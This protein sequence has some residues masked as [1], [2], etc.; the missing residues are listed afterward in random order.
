MSGCKDKA[1][2]IACFCDNGSVVWLSPA[3]RVSVQSAIEIFSPLD[4]SG[5]AEFVK[6]KIATF[7]VGHAAVMLVGFQIRSGASWEME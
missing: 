4:V 7:I 1:S 2:L 3:R 5:A 6:R